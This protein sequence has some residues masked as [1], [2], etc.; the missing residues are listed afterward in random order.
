M[1]STPDLSYFV[2]DYDRA[3]SEARNNNKLILVDLY[4]DWC[5]PCRQIDAKVFDNPQVRHVLTNHFISVKIDVDKPGRNNE[6][7]N[8]FGTRSI[9]HVVFLNSAGEKLYEFTGFVSASVFL[10]TLQALVKDTQ[11]KR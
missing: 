3:L 5:G 2:T 6:L 4:A 10:D 1:Y 7:A 9:P 8:Q 11:T